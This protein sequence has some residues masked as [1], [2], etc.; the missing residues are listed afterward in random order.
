MF[1][2][3]FPFRKPPSSPNN[4]RGQ[5]GGERIQI[6][7]IGRLA[8]TQRFYRAAFCQARTLRQRPSVSSAKLLVDTLVVMIAEAEAVAAK[9]PNK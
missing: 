2:H 7:R 8:L 5:A 4:C 9:Q 3:A 6:N 1:E